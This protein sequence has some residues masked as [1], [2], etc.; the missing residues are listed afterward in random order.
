MGRHEREVWVR[1][2][3]IWELDE[4]RPKGGGGD[5]ITRPRTTRL[6]NEEKNVGT[7]TEGKPQRSTSA[8]ELNQWAKLFSREDNKE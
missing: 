6:H 7:K 1:R 8:R 2:L 4:G 3:S 5:M